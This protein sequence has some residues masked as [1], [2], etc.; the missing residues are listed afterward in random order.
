[1]VRTLPS[2]FAP[3]WLLTPIRVFVVSCLDFDG[4]SVGRYLAL[5]GIRTHASDSLEDEQMMMDG[6]LLRD[7]VAK[8][9]KEIRHLRMTHE[10]DWRNHIRRAFNERYSTWLQAANQEIPEAE[11]L[12]GLCCDMGLG[13]DTSRHRE[14]VAW[15]ERAAGRGFGEAQYYLACYHRFG[16][17]QLANERNE[18]LTLLE[19]AAASE[20]SDALF[21]LALLYLEQPERPEEW[22]LSR[23]ADNILRAAKL[24]HLEARE[25]LLAGRVSSP[26]IMEW[27]TNDC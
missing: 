18:M 25:T 13:S 3:L 4:R 20:Q 8:D 21:E 10:D 27:L 16:L 12:V 15:F 2:F 9:I 17:G 19:Q 11:W 1:M 6:C 24:G 22:N 5:A 23:I 7:E 26:E 14:A